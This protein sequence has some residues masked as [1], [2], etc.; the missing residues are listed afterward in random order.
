MEPLQPSTGRS[1]RLAIVAVALLALLAV[2]AFASRS[3]LG[4]SGRAT[5]TPGYVNYAFTAF[6]I[7]FVLAIPVAAYGFLLQA[8]ETTP[9]RKSFRSRVIQNILTVVFFLV[10]ALILFYIKR[11]HGKL[12]QVDT[13]G[14]KNA[15]EAIKS[16]PKHVRANY[17]PRFEWSV[18]WIAVAALTVAAVWLYV[19]HRQRK[20]RKAI[21]LDRSGDVAEELAATMSESIDDLEAEPDARRAVIAAYARMEAVLARNGLKRRP[22]ETPLEYLRRILLGLTA[23]TDAV[24]QLT[25]LFEQAKFSRHDVDDAMKQRAIDS[26]RVIRDDLRSVPA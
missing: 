14:L 20:S 8:R 5:P 7:V 16:R 3:G 13:S 18:F 23:R 15:S 12:F 19:S 6:L 1:W 21:P 26:L 9:E 11:H 4:H 25:Q 2:V 10:L 24:T 22:S 17:E